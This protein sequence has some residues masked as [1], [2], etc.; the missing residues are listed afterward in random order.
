M[1]DD[2][3]DDVFDALDEIES[4]CITYRRGNQSVDL[5]AVVGETRSIDDTGKGQV[6]TS[7]TRD[8]LIRTDALVL[9]GEQVEPRT[10]DKIEQEI[11]G[12]ATTWTVRND[13][14]G[15]CFRYSDRSRRRLRIHTQER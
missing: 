11:N 8:Y 10:L 14:A 6:I 7:R 2:L 12:V 9:N 3:L 5:R 1:L 4:V 13:D 15:E